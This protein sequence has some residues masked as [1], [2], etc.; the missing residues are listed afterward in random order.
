MKYRV[1]HTTGYQYAE[2][3]PFCQNILHLKPRATARQTLLSHA[4]TIAPAP[5]YRSERTDFFGNSA[6]WFSLQTP[7]QAI[8][9]TARSEVDVALFE[10]PTG[11]WPSGWET[12]VQTLAGRRDP[13]ILD[14]LQFTF[15][16]QMVKTDPEL[17]EYARPSFAPGRQLLECATELTTR[18]YKDFTF[19]S[20]ATTVGTPVLDVLHHRHGVCQDFAH[21]QIACLRSLGLAARYVSGY[22]LTKPPQGRPR[23]VGADSSHAWVSVF[24]PEAGWIDFDPTNGVLPSQE[25]ITLGWARDYDDVSPV[26]GVVVGGRRHTLVV[27][28]DVEP[29]AA[30]AAKVAAAGAAKA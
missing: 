19:D 25:H 24:F 5:A 29:A 3:I 7:H 27:S 22:L 1:I 11:L 30:A 28:V 14:A 16:S 26:R 21:L 23:L 18:I 10:P 8:K 2:P 6:T 9:I 12:V 20:R 17:A 4:L 13:E 15:D